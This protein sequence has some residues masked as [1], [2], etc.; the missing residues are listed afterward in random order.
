MKATLKSEFLKLLTIRSTY[1]LTIITVVIIAGLNFYFE[2][3]RGSTG[4]AASMLQPT[5]IQE[6]LTNT[7]GFAVLFAA[8]IAILFVAHEYRYN[9]IMY[10]LT[11]TARRTK[12][13]L[14]KTLAI[15]A[16]GLV[17]GAI[18]LAL[19]T[20][21]YMLGV[22]YRSGASLPAQDVDVWL[23]LGKIALYFVIYVL[24][25]LT[26]ALLV[27]S[28]VAAIVVLMIFPSTIEPLL[29]LILKDNAKYL[30][31]TAIDGMLGN[32]MTVNASLSVGSAAIVAVIYVVALWLLSWFLFVRRDA[33]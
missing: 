1:V 18:V 28:V 16:F 31:F 32:G 29:G 6:I 10:T 9:M 17:F 13:L 24:V 30:P 27:R 15:S 4:S 11:A 33:N 20:G 26:I 8:I 22:A 12:V 2:G 14:A 19:G 3:F 21:A 23:T 7:A 25:G 5:A